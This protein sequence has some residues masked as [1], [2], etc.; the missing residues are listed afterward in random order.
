MQGSS[1]LIACADAG[2]VVQ[3]LPKRA[4]LSMQAKASDSNRQPPSSPANQPSSKW[5]T[6]ACITDSIP[7][8]TKQLHS[9]P[10]NNQAVAHSHGRP[11]QH[12]PEARVG[13][14]K[15]LSGSPNTNSVKL[16]KEKTDT[17]RA[18]ASAPKFAGWH[19]A[20]HSAP[21][22]SRHPAAHTSGAGP[23]ALQDVG[24]SLGNAPASLDIQRGKLRSSEGASKG[25]ASPGLDMYKRIDANSHS[26]LCSNARHLSPRDVHKS[27]MSGHSQCDYPLDAA[28]VGSPQVHPPGSSSSGSISGD[29]D[30]RRRSTRGKGVLDSHDATAVAD[31]RQNIRS[32]SQRIGMAARTS[33]KRGTTDVH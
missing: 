13:K 8:E 7:A 17:L 15:S 26:I 19:Q 5:P 24:D 21:S 27:V 4:T 22:T 28:S 11:S 14:H 9:S 30:A 29:P 3:S 31:L 23:P 12:L 10:L 6:S 18:G 25:R 1:P 16:A 2:C 20:S 32:L 33:R